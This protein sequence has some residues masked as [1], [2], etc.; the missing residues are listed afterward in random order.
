MNRTSLL[1]AAVAAT[2]VLAAPSAALAGGSSII[3]GPVK[4]KG[5]DINITAPD[6]ARRTAS[7]CWP[8]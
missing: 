3:A 1:C 7:A 4:V 6:N 8:S 5:Y 2:G